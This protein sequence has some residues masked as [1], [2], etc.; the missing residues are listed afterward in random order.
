MR[1]VPAGGV[2]RHL[3]NSPPFGL[4]LR[5]PDASAKPSSP[6]RRPGD[7]APHTSWTGHVE[8][9]RLGDDGLIDNIEF[10]NATGE[11]G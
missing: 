5:L 11:R 1:Q 6:P 8:A 4:D 7:R 10:D 2:A 9:R 3:A